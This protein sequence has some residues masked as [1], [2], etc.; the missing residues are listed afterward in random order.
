MKV[1][2]CGQLWVICVN[3]EVASRGQPDVPMCR[4]DSARAAAVNGG[5]DGQTAKLVSRTNMDASANHG[6]SASGFNLKRTELWGKSGAS[7]KS[8]IFDT[9][10]N[11]N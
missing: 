7:S 1:L 5:I 10:P 8:S 2:Q 6:I 4:A 3:C 11:F 9:I